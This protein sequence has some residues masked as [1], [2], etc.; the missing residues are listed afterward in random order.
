MQTPS[1]AAVVRGCPTRAFCA[2]LAARFLSYVLYTRGHAPPALLTLPWERLLR[3]S[4]GD[5][6]GS[7]GDVDD[8]DDGDGDGHL[9]DGG[10]GSAAER[11][12]ASR[13][14]RDVGA[15]VEAV[16]AAGAACAQTGAARLALLIG[17]SAARPKEAYVLELGPER[18]D[19]APAGTA[20]G[21]ELRG[22][23]C[24]LAA[25]LSGEAPAGD[26]LR[27][28]LHVLVEAPALAG[29]P[30]GFAVHQTAAGA[31]YRKC[32]AP[33]VTV[34]LADASDPQSPR[35]RGVGE[36]RCWYRY[37]GLVRS[38]PDACPGDALC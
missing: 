9:G 29:P 12:R 10:G 3:P 32:M 4:A 34:R 33:A 24:A 5:P 2:S 23:M 26:G 7:G 25:A 6:R 21:R 17:H 18:A 13:R 14:A 22:A 35:G 31:P 30:Q 36:E 8:V 1:A 20:P 37:A 11:R 15:L 27:T 28:R 16:R 38:V 19:A